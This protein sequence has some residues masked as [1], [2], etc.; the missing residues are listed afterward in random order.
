MT[1]YQQIIS[2][3]TGITKLEYIEQIEEVIRIEYPCLDGL[4][5]ASIISKAKVAHEVWRRI[6]V[7]EMSSKTLVAWWNTLQF[8]RRMGNADLYRERL[9]RAE[10]HNR[11]IPHEIGKL[12]GENR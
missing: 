10:M 2:E 9:A 1:I 4:T 8:A 5:K 11:E 12:T 3:A 6:Q 7:S